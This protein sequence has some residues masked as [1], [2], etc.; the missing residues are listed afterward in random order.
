MPAPTVIPGIRVNKTTH[1]TRSK[2][3]PDEWAQHA[4]LLA[5]QEE[6]VSVHD[7][8]RKRVARD[9][10]V[11][12]NELKAE[13]TRLARIVTTHEV[14]TEL[15]VDVFVDAAAGRVMYVADMEVTEDGHVFGRILFT[16]SAS[17][18][19]IS[20]ARAAEE[21]SFAERQS[22]LFPVDGGKATAPALTEDANGD[23]VSEIE[24]VGLTAD[25]DKFAPSVGKIAAAVANAFRDVDPLAARRLVMT[26]NDTGDPVVLGRL[27]GSALQLGIDQLRVVGAKVKVTRV[28]GAAVDIDELTERLGGAAGAKLDEEVASLVPGL[29]RLDEEADEAFCNRALRAYI[30]RQRAAGPAKPVF[31]VPE[32][33]TGDPEV[34]GEDDRDTVEKVAVVLTKVPKG[35]KTKAIALVRRSGIESLGTAKK[36]VDA[37]VAGT[38]MKLGDYARANAERFVAKLAEVGCETAP[39]A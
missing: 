4:E 30:V 22:A 3:A 7:D 9:L 11:R 21:R 38:A 35:G 17:E 25:D 1:E 37:V 28:S 12:L 16:S 33:G 8:Y 18:T 32:G 39:L 5:M 2:L 14:E 15:E 26:H 36:L 34:E 20:R 6:R 13:R 23:I 19:D 31:H 27:S 29:V 24:L 10:N